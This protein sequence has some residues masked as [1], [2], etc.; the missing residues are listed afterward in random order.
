MP[1]EKSHYTV[2]EIA[3]DLDVSTET[4]RTWIRNGELKA[5]DIGKGYR[6]PIEEYH[7]FLKARS[8]SKQTEKKES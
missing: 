7:R 2:K 3:I 8:T 1:V 5:I 6:I 4:V